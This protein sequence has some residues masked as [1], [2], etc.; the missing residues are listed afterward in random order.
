MSLKHGD[1]ISDE[2]EL[3]IP[4]HYKIIL[5]LANQLDMTINFFAIKRKKL[6]FEDI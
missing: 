5:L 6:V 3:V 1:L 2:K 4:Y